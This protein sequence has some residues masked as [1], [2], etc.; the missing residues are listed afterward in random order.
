MAFHAHRLAVAV[1]FLLFVAAALPSAAQST[2]GKVRNI[3][4]AE[5]RPVIA[6][7]TADLPNDFPSGAASD[8]R[9]WAEYVEK[10]DKEL[11]ARLEQGDFDT[12]ANL[13]LFG[14][15]YTKAPVIT[16]EML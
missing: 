13:L 5:A 8:P 12:L 16:P 3:A 1:E 6:S 4:L 9:L 14:T 7:H 2:T 10:R 15:S 11:R